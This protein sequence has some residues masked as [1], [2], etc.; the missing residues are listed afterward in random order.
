MN[1]FLPNLP[2]RLRQ[3]KHSYALTKLGGAQRSDSLKPVT[4][5]E[6][7]EEELF[8]DECPLSEAESEI[9]L[10]ITANTTKMTKAKGK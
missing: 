5:D 4:P 7:E 8:P 10:K 1:A 9:D 2:Q 6:E 3:L